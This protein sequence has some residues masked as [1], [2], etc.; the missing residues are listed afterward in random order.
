MSDLKSPLF[1]TLEYDRIVL[2]KELA[3]MPIVGGL[4]SIVVVFV[5]IKPVEYLLRG[6]H[7]Q[8]PITFYDWFQKITQNLHHFKAG[9]SEHGYELRFRVR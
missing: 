4:A 2:R 6:I 3:V 9:I 1:K 8:I 7:M 5:G